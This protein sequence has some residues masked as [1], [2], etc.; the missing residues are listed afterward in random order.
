VT[1]PHQVD[2]FVR[3]HE[4]LASARV[5]VRAILGYLGEDDGASPRA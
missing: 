2:E 3:L 5:Y 1:I 4:V